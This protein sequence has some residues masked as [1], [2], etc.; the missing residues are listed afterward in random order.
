M[1]NLKLL[2]H[3]TFFNFKDSSI[4]YFY[5]IVTSSLPS[6]DV[7]YVLHIESKDHNG[8]NINEWI[9]FD[10]TSCD[11]F[12]GIMTLHSHI[13]DSID[14]YNKFNNDLASTII[15]EDGKD[16]LYNGIIRHINITY[17]TYI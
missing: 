16:L 8:V 4:N 12:T 3:D 13:S 14:K 5:D 15:F 6:L 17:Y 2:G 11:I 10:V 7:K 9:A 1:T